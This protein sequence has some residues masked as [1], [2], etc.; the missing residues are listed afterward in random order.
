[1]KVI[2]GNLV[3]LAL[4]GKFD[5]IVHGCNC[6]C[7]MGAG[8]AKTIKEF[9]PEAYEADLH[10]TKGDR[11]KLGGYSYATYTQELSTGANNILTII[12]AYTQYDYKSKG[13]RVD[14]S[15]LE[16]VMMTIRGRYRRK[17]IG[18][19]K[20]GA[21]LAKG[22]WGK[23]SEIIDRT[24]EGVDHTLVEYDGSPVEECFQNFF[25]K[26]Y[27]CKTCNKIKK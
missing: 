14:Y 24:L 11:E 21:G 27:V 8:I 2:K 9:F 23:I 25:Q 5:V 7:T 10:T 6:F 18:F 12:N 4:E 3:Q 17:R 19:P 22:D 20:I 15:A 1:M 13:V 26:L 16:N